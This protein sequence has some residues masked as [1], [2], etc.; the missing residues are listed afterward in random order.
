LKQDQYVPL[1]VEKQILIVY[2]GTQGYTDKLPVDS[3]RRYERELYEYVDQKHPELWTNIVEKKELTDEL[4]TQLD[5]VLKEFTSAFSKS[6]E[7]SA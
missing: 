4:K 3:L 5:K 1:A 7:A 6:L 2:A